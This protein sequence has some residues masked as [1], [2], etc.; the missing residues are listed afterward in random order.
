LDVH[1]DLRVETI[2]RVV[3][4]TGNAIAKADDVQRDGREQLQVRIRSDGFAER[5]RQV[6]GATDR[7]A[8]ALDAVMPQR[9]PNLE[10][11]KLA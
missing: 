8:E 4:E 6:A 9:E 1:R 7:R 5:A 3:V 11:A 2:E 10:R